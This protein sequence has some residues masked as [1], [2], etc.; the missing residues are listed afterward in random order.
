VVISA[1]NTSSQELT[2][3][4]GLDSGMG[5]N[6]GVRLDCS[7][8]PFCGV[9]SGRVGVLVR[10][11]TVYGG[12]VI[13]VGLGCRVD[14]SGGAVRFCGARLGVLEHFI[15]RRRVHGRRLEGLG[16]SAEGRE[17]DGGC[18]S[19][20]ARYVVQHRLLFNCTAF[21]DLARRSFGAD[22]EDPEDQGE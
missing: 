13:G 8:N 14:L 10:G 16:V 2:A 6:G 9:V 17:G 12:P 20:L 3:C 7:I 18:G 1:E 15:G 5:L 19:R 11:H 21:Y 4:D 22:H